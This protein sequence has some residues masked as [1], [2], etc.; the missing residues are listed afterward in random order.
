MIYFSASTEI[1]PFSST[2]TFRLFSP[3]GSPQDLFLG[4]FFSMISCLL[5]LVCWCGF[6]IHRTDWLLVCFSWS[7]WTEYL[8]ETL[9]YWFKAKLPWYKFSF[10]SQTWWSLRWGSTLPI[11]RSIF[12]RFT[13]SPPPPDCFIPQHPSAYSCSSLL[14]YFFQYSP[15]CT[16]H[17][18]IFS[19]SSSHY[20]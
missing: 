13:F 20:C 17:V 3:D 18:A 2:P 12:C 1:F 8:T 16:R 5:S 19:S 6:F 14:S 9:R 11:D 4:N 7:L 10:I 15:T